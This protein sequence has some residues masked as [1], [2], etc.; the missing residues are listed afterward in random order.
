MYI[1]RNLRGSVLITQLMS[2]S[3][4]SAAFIIL[5]R[6]RGD[7]E[8]N[9]MIYLLL[10]NRRKERKKGWNLA[11]RMQQCN[12]VVHY[13]LRIFD[14]IGKILNTYWQIQSEIFTTVSCTYVS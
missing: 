6:R 5:R 2:R 14:T 3:L 9:Q 11:S 10:I 13:F 1:E 12:L 4:I 7:S 8:I